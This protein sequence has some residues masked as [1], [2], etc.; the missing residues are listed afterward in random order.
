MK[1]I[2]IRDMSEIPF[3]HDGL[4]A[5]GRE[6]LHN[7]PDGTPVWRPEYEEDAT[8]N[9]P[10]N[11]VEFGDMGSY[12]PSKFARLGMIHVE[13]E[14]RINYLDAVDPAANEEKAT[15][16]HKCSV[17]ERLRDALMMDMIRRGEDPFDDFL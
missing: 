10:T 13:S 2:V 7:L 5:T 8:C 4:H 14:I 16:L 6:V 9:M 12:F 1:N 15:L 17:A 11:Y 3:D